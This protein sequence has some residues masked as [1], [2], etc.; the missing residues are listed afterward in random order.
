[1]QGNFIWAVSQITYGATLMSA[2]AFHMH[3]G[4]SLPPCRYSIV[5]HL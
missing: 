2:D 1:M 5:S 4:A 3:W